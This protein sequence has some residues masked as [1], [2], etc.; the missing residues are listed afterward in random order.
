MLAYP[1]IRFQE[2]LYT[3]FKIVINDVDIS[4][5]TIFGI[6]IYHMQK[7]WLDVGPVNGWPDTTVFVSCCS[8][9]PDAAKGRRW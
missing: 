4:I 2:S 9:L 3:I 7:R 5:Y 8:L 1:Y 6:D